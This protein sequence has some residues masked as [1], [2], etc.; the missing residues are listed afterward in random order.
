VT[1]KQN[2]ILDVLYLQLSSL[3]EM[4]VEGSF[5]NLV[6]CTDVHYNTS[7]KIPFDA[8]GSEGS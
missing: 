6:P 2:F 4:Q 8:D 5:E 1:D 3:L 7:E